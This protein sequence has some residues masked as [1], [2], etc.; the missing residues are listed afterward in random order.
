[1]YPDVMGWYV[2]PHVVYDERCEDCCSGNSGVKI[3]FVRQPVASNTSAS[4]SSVPS[5]A[6]VSVTSVAWNYIIS[7]IGSPRVLEKLLKDFVCK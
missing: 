7:S 1:M 3:T 4:K 5:T 2:R 6:C